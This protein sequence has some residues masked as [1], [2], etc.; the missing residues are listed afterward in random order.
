MELTRRAPCP[1]HTYFMFFLRRF[2]R[3]QESAGK[4]YEGCMEGGILSD[5][6]TGFGQ[7]PGKRIKRELVS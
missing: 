4:N 7:L 1:F 6:A 5:H 2:L 3:K